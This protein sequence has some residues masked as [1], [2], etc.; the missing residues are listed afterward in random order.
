MEQLFMLLVMHTAYKTFGPHVLH[1]YRD[2][3]IS[4]WRISKW[5]RSKTEH[6]EHHVGHFRSSDNV[7][8]IAALLS[9]QAAKQTL[10]L[11]VCVFSPQGY[12][13][14]YRDH[15]SLK[16]PCVL[17]IN[18]GKITRF[19]FMS[20]FTICLSNMQ[21]SG[22]PMGGMWGSLSCSRTLKKVAVN[23]QTL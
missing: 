8:H 1:V 12:P 2:L 4:V 15:Q 5:P 9:W 16:R 11:G 7:T 21:S 19:A 20:R 18:I 3:A 17:P 23:R 14:S 6:V 10:I 13:S 22:Q